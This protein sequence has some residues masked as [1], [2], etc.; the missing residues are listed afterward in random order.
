M[1]LFLDEEHGIVSEA[2]VDL[3]EDDC[4]IMALDVELVNEDLLNCKVMEGKLK[5]I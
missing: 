2:S 1:N 5:G 3:L 4:T